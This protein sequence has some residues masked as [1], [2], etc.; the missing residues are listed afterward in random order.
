[1]TR[2]TKGSARHTGAKRNKTGLTR[3]HRDH[4]QRKTGLETD[5]QK[6]TGETK[7]WRRHAERKF[8]DKFASERGR[9]RK[10]GK[11]NRENHE[12][13]ATQEAIRH[14]THQADRGSQSA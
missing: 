6:M 5:K 8:E 7:G 14:E 9:A 2:D 4:D 10:R 1:M 3:E 12:K 11:G 13:G